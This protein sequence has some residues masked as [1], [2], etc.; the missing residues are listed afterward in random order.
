MLKGIH[1]VLHPLLAL[2]GDQAIRFQEGSN[3]YGMIEAIN[4]DERGKNSKWRK[5]FIEHISN[6]SKATSSTVFIFTSPQFLAEHKDVHDVLMT[7]CLNKR[8]FRSFTVDEAHLIAQHGGSFRSEIH[9]IGEEFIMPI[10]GSKVPSA[11]YRPFFLAMSATVSLPDM[12]LFSNLTGVGFPKEYRMWGDFDHFQ[13]ENCE[14]GIRIGS[15]YTTSLNI[16]VDHLKEHA[17]AAF[18]FTNGR[19]LS[20]HLVDG[21]E[22]KL[23]ANDINCDVV[24]IHGR[25]RL[26]DKMNFIKL[27]TQKIKVSDYKPLVL[28]ATSA[29]DLGVDHP[30]AQCGLNNEWPDSICTFVQRRG[31]ASRRD[32]IAIIVIVAGVASFIHLTKRILSNVDIYNN[33]D[34]E[35]D[36]DTTSSGYNNLL[37]TP[38]KGP[39]VNRR[40]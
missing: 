25:L 2:T 8:T 21:I 39:S 16:V 13:M 5:R 12:T 14:I 3:D 37:V 35:D 11:E 15:A 26:E 33:D 24:H 30:N 1:V 22:S 4:L 34:G 38:K 29:G 40:Q 19:A 17:S 32:E 9:M 27:Y 10:F 23:D 28:I 6:L 36:A 31:R 7:V 18:V 20:F